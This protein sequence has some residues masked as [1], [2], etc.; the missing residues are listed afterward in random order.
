MDSTRLSLGWGLSLPVG[1]QISI[2]V[3]FNALNFGARPGD[4]QRQG[5]LNIN[6]GFF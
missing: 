6:M 3:Y 5:Y 1:E 4:F 2:L